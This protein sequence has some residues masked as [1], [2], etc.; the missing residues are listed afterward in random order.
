MLASFFARPIGCLCHFFSQQEHFK[1]FYHRLI[2][3]IPKGTIPLFYLSLSLSGQTNKHP[4]LF[5]LPSE[6]SRQLK[7]P[8]STWRKRGAEM[9][10]SKRWHFKQHELARW[11]PSYAIVLHTKKCSFFANLDPECQFLFVLWGILLRPK[12]VAVLDWEL[13]KLFFSSSSLVLTLILLYLA[14]SLNGSLFSFSSSSSSLSLFFAAFLGHIL[15]QCSWLFGIS[16]IKDLNPTTLEHK[17]H[18]RWTLLC[19]SRILSCF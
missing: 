6:S 18:T 14:S 10:A 5:Y 16:K 7:K 9:A 2:L 15:T 4:K 12:I 3:F 19:M 1:A 13:I 17:D 11:W 8:H